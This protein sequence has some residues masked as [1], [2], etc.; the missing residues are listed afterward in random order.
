MKSIGRVMQPFSEHHLITLYICTQFQENISKGFRVTEQT[1]T[2][3]YK[4]GLFHK[5][6]RWSYCTCSVTSPDNAL[7]LYQ[8]SRKYHKGFQSYS[9][10]AVCIL[11]FSM[12]HNSVHS[13][14]VA[15]VLVLSIL[16]DGVLYLYQVLSK[17]LK[18]FQS[19]GFE[20]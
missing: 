10:A 15:M 18:G 20:Q 7:Y 13:V 8:V 4:G 5:K 14:G 11:K 9:E 17:Y 1:H 2:K 19:Y 3:I 6:C 12:G 16:S